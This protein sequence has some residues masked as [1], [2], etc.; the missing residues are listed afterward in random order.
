MIRHSTTATAMLLAAPLMAQ[1]ALPQVNQSDL[2]AL[3]AEGRM[4]EA[5]LFAFEAG[6]ELTEHSFTAEQGVGAYIEEGR[7]FTRVPR[8]DLDGPM[9]WANHLPWREG[10]ANAT[11]CIACHNQPLPNGAGDVALNV[12]VDPYHTGDPAL[13]L[14]RNTL[15]LFALGVPQRLAEEMTTD[16]HQQRA[17]AILAACSD[18]SA[19][20]ALDS[21]DVTFGTLIVTRTATEPCAWDIDTSAVTGV[22]AD[23]IVRPFGWKGNEATIRSFTRNAAHNELGLQA[24]ELVGDMDGDFDGVT[25]EL[26]VGD[27]TALTIYMAAL[28]RPVSMLELDD[29]GL[30]ELSSDDRAEI[31]RGEALFAE[32]DCTSCH[33]PSLPIED[34][35]FREPSL[36]PGFYDVTFPAGTDPEV[37]GLMAELTLYF[38]M[39]TDQPNNMVELA[40]G[41]TTHLGALP[42]AADGTATAILYTDLRR[43]DMGAELADPTDLHGIPATHFLTRS[44]AGVGSTGPW[45]HDGRA[46][47]LHDAAMAHGGAAAASRDA[48]AALTTEDQAAISAFLSNLIIFSTGEEEDH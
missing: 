3:V 20:V 43:H 4:E 7:I 12:L 6:D 30:M 31:L 41:T 14:E 5:F 38:D 25:G 40:D 29:L 36:T 45:L 17:D 48:Y 34:A 42:V 16:L 44:L 46:T 26:T 18:G 27:L 21:K 13:Y 10:G 22:S 23:L 1:E 37:A 15:P 32:A 33:I 39:T 28:E 19:E 2:N 47:T 9:E 8:A 24:D 11:S 35:V